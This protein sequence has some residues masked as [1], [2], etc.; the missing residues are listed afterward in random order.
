MLTV[1]QQRRRNDYRYFNCRT[2]TSAN[3]RVASCFNSG[4]IGGA[5]LSPIVGPSDMRRH[6]LYIL[7]AAGVVVV[8]VG[9]VYSQKPSG[10][11]GDVSAAYQGLT[12]NPGPGTSVYQHFSVVGNGRGVHALFGVTNLTRKYYVNFGIAAVETPGSEGWKAEDSGVSRPVLGKGIPP[13]DGYIFAIPWPLG[14]KTDQPWR[15]RLWVTRDWRLLSA[16]LRHR[17]YGLKVYGH[18]T[19]TSTGCGTAKLY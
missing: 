9:L 5:W 4:A 14:L 7:L 1:G 6:G 19:V 16:K 10:V 17:G 15:L 12:N 13:G 2:F 11:A 3:A 8:C 18:H